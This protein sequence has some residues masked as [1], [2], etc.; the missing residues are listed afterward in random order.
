MSKI[1]LRSLAVCCLALASLSAAAAQKTTSVCSVNGPGGNTV[2][3]TSNLGGV[4]LPD[5]AMTVNNTT[6][7]AKKAFIQFSAD[8][9]IDAT[10]E[11]RLTF[12]IDN[13]PTLYS[14]PQNLAN[15]A[16]YYQARS[17]VAVLSI[18]PGVHTIRP[19]VFV[20]GAPGLSGYVD[21]RCMIVTF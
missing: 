5:V 4:Y 21:D 9:G 17:T 19:Y 2:V 12:G 10:A 8:A 20:Q 7:A 11:L 18:P 15:H 14:G 13:G 1:Y 3:T 6:S 16:E